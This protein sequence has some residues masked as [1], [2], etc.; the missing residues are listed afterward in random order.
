MKSYIEQITINSINPILF[1][2]LV[3]GIGSRT[4]SMR[5]TILPLAIVSNI[6]LFVKYFSQTFTDSIFILSHILQ[7][8]WVSILAF[9]MFFPVKKLTNI[10]PFLLLDQQTISF[11]F[12]I[13]VKPSLISVLSALILPYQLAPHL[14]IFIVLPGKRVERICFLPFSVKLVIDD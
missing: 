6:A 14:L 12:F 7:P 4:L 8:R 13:L 9:S 2:E 10:F 5:Q 3:L 1:H 11:K